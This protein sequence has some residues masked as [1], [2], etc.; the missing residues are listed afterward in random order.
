MHR[1]S[2]STPAHD[3]L[4]H[5]VPF[6]ALATS[7]RREIQA[8]AFAAQDEALAAVRRATWRRVLAAVGRIGRAVVDFWNIP[9]LGPSDTRR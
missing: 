2:S 3:G 9:V 1:N 6:N 4:T 7:V 8:K 5:S